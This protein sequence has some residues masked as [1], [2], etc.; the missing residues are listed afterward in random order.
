MRRCIAA[1]ALVAL[2][3]TAAF[4]QDVK[5]VLANASKAMGVDNLNSVHYYGAAANFQVGQSNNANGQWPRTNVNDYM[6]A[7]DFTQS[8]ARASGVTF[9]APV[10]GGPAAQGAFNQN[11]TATNTGWAQQLEIWTTPWGFLK[12]ATANNAT[13][14][15]QTVGGKRYNVVTWMTTQKAPSGASYPVVGYINP[16]TNLVEKV[17]TKLEHP[18]FGDMLI[19]N[20]YTEYREGGG[21]IKFPAFMVQKRVGQPTF[22]AQLLGAFANPANLQQLMTPPARGGGPGPGAGAPA[23]GPPAGGAPGGAPAD[24]GPTSEKLA[25]GVWRLNGP[26]NALAV[27]F[28]DHV[29]LF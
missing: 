28:R 21:G 7:I 9:A 10:T 12:G 2:T 22:E 11:I 5:T 14:K 29:V 19:E 15:A 27:E 8:A 3:S 4:A 1:I 26:Y 20:I 13:A 23:G 17:E 25:E 24:A 6:R 16:Q 18:F